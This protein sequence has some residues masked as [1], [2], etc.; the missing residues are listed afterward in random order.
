MTNLFENLGDKKILILGFGEEGKSTYRILRSE[1]PEKQIFI[2][3]KK[4]KE[5][6][7]KDLPEEVKKDLYLTFILGE[8]YLSKIKDFDY[9]IKAPGIPPVKEPVTT[10]TELFF[11]LCKGKIVGVTGTKGKST[12]STLIFEICKKAGL[13]VFLIGNIGKPALEILK[14][15]NSQDAVY[16]YELSSHQLHG[17]RK[18]PHVAVVLNVG[19]DHLDWHGSQDG[20]VSAKKN[21]VSFQGSHDY[22]ILNANDKVVAGFAKETK[23]Q[24]ILF[25]GESLG[26]KYKEKLL[27]RGKHNWDNVS[28]AIKV[29]EIFGVEESHIISVLESFKGLEHRLEV[30]R[31]YQ[32]ITF[33]ND[34]ISTNPVS[35]K[36]AITSFSE[37]LTLI[38]G[39]YDRGINYEDLAKSISRQQNIKKILLTGEV[40]GIMEEN[41]KEAG[42]H[43]ELINCGQEKMEILVKKAFAMTKKGGIVLLSPGAA[44]FDMFKDYKERGEKFKEAVRN[45]K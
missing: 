20:Y 19:T 6:L 39:G 16:I 45:L 10:Q 42:Y 40:S 30:V 1:Y 7:F 28:A 25:S 9:I 14:K 37:D 13:K 33:V 23:G 8:N 27:L 15:E 2:A 11:G 31:E 44:S 12:T 24:V 5:E 17:L 38:M 4:N 22:A 43:G 21:I 29:A 3:D 41:L 35:L 36:A 32:R 18:S 26:A 34:S